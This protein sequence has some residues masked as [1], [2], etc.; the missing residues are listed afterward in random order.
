MTTP[1]PT[2]KQP[3]HRD[4][5]VI[6]ASAGGVAALLALV[7]TLPADFPAPI[8]VV[9]H[10]AA[11]SPS[12][13]PHLLNS[14]SALEA[15]HPHD[16]ET[17]RAGVIYVAPPDHHLLLEG[18]RVLVTRGPKENRF[19]PS[20]DALFRSAAYTYGPRVIGVVLTGYLDDGTSGLW[21]VQR[22]GGLTI[23]QEPDDAEQPS[24]PTN[25]LE[26]VAADYVVPLAQLGPLLGRLTRERAPAKTRLPAAALDLLKIELTIAKQGGGF[27][28]GIID[29]GKLTPFTCPDCHGA[30]TQLIEGKLIRYRCHTGH[31]YTVSALLSE[32]T[33][34]VEGLLY[35]SMRGLEETKML[36]QNLGRHFA[37]DHQDP[38]AALFFRKADETGQQA[39]VVHDSIL[40]HEALSGD[41][42]FERKKLA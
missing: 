14:A 7:K 35:Q 28:L 23:V 6:G 10:V 33:Q 1:R 19:R 39:R 13:L 34:S 22:M 26:F 16:G 20:I 37:D 21:S 4:I 17:V 12:L 5:V 30:L 38:V 42:Q 40:K 27:E 9:I 31:A 2:K 8:F 32:V 3:S 24:M 18:D 11:D 15:R 41:L 25:A 29:K 36:L